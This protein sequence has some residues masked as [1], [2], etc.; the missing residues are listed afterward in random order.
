MIHI[1]KKVQPDESYNLAAQ[2]HVKVSLEQPECTANSDAF[3]PAQ[4]ALGHPYSGPHE[5]DALLP[6]F[7]FRD[8][9]W[10]RRYRSQKTTPSHVCD[11]KDSESQFMDFT[12]TFS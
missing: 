3:R 7:H 12:T 10:C 4:T 2:S 5:E 11:R 8:L 6:G 9:G 1:V